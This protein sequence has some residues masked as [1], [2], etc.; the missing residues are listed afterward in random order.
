VAEVARA[1][2]APMV[3]NVQGDEPLIHPAMIDQLAEYLQLH[4][5]VPMVSL[6]TTLKR[7]EDMANPNVVKVV[8]DRAGFALYF[9]RAPIPFARTPQSNAHP[10]LCFKHLGIYGYQR[11][12][13]LQFPHLEPTPLEQLEQL[14]QL[15]ALEH[16]YR[17]KLLETEH[18]TV[19]VDTP[20]DL[21]NVERRA[22]RINDG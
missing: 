18:D 5:A 1:R 6:M 3:I 17:L 11:Y 21:V 16:G 12:F 22:Q 10:A 14:E 15:R 13:L 2:R 19:G 7:P 8:V 4:G 9:S 20:E